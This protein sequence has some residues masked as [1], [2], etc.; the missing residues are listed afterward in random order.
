MSRVGVAAVLSLEDLEF[1][2]CC[3]HSGEIFLFLIRE[4]FHEYMS[5]LLYTKGTHRQ[6]NTRK[7]H[8]TGH[9]ES[10][11]RLMEA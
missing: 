6:A 11:F 9:G 8:G 10:L 1:S 7:R 3:G 2:R 5:I 4:V